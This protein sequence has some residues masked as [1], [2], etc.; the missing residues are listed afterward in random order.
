M[1]VYLTRVLLGKGKREWSLEDWI[2]EGA[3]D[4]MVNDI[5]NSNPGI[6]V[7]SRPSWVGNFGLIASRKQCTAGLVVIVEESDKLKEIIARREPKMLV[8]G[9]L[10]FCRVWRERL[11]MVKCN[12]CLSV[13]YTLPEFKVTL[14]CRWCEKSHLSTEHKCPIVDCAAPKGMFCQ[15]C[16]KDCMLCGQKDHFMGFRECDVLKGTTTTLPRYGPATP[17]EAD[18]PSA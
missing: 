5:K 7:W 17:V 3:F 16:P 2:G 18:N 9:R 6:H 8:G 11:D 15:H 10:R 13:R 12:R 1:K 4:G 14:V